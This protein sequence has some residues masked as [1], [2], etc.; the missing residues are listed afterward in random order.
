MK[1]KNKK[2]KGKAR[3]LEFASASKKPATNHR[4]E[5]ISD[6]VI[7]LCFTVLLLAIKLAAEQT[8]FI[9][10]LQAAAY[11]W[12]LGTLP[13]GNAFAEVPTVVDV[14]GLRPIPL[15]DRSLP[16][17]TDRQVLLSLIKA[18]AA[19]RP[20]AIGVD[21]D[22]APDQQGLFNLDDQHFFRECLKIR[23]EMNIPLF[24]GVE[25][26]KNKPSAY[27][28]GNSE[29]KELA[30]AVAI[31]TDN[32]GR[33][34]KWVQA[35]AG[36]QAAR[37]ERQNEEPE[38]LISMSTALAADY[39]ESAVDRSP[40]LR[41]ALEHVSERDESGVKIGEYLVNY[42]QLDAIRYGT[43]TTWNPEEIPN[44]QGRLQRRM[45]I[46]GKTAWLLAS[47]KF[48]VPGQSETV[49]GVYLHA[50]GAWTLKYSRI[51]QTTHTGRI[52]LD[53]F[54]SAAIIL[55][56]AGIRLYVYARTGVR[57]G[58]H[59]LQWLLT[60]AMALLSFTVG[61]LF[62]WL[63]RVVWDDFIVAL[64]VLMIH[65]VVEEKSRNFFSFIK[66][67]TGDVLKKLAH[68]DNSK[69]APK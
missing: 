62:F 69:E 13:S 30:A 15:K 40:W 24:L 51:Y 16:F 28:L 29:F 47:D 39:E 50:C 56:I 36:P 49:V 66:S 37:A 45:V 53:L 19:Q 10:G 58:H 26:T 64:F 3:I 1:K 61:V 32:I 59:L 46:V 2:G 65:P 54:L 68:A 20:S 23:K 52:V 18:I 25:R 21:I 27:W 5:I 33:I 31:P 48:N 6:L 22:F 42:S 63:T 7:G 9:K 43:V 8:L 34:L 17:Y 14:S 57:T 35:E 4:Q 44:Y 11:T 60:Y 38:R 55:A 67:V 12:L 41:W